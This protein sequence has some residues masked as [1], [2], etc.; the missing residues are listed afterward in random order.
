MDLESNARHRYDGHWEFL[1]TAAGL[2]ASISKTI[3]GLSAEELDKGAFG[4]AYAPSIIRERIDALAAW[5]MSLLS[6]V[7][8]QWIP[9]KSIQGNWWWASAWNASLRYL[10]QL[11][12]I[13]REDVEVPELAHEVDILYKSISPP[14]ILQPLLAP[15]NSRIL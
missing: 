9:P 10:K 6:D 8:E 5:N 15:H 14:G 12:T 2:D 1:A 11:G 3:S 4:L 7:V 13:R